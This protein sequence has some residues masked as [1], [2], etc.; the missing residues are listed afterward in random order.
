MVFLEIGMILNIED[1]AT[2]HFLATKAPRHQDA[3]YLKI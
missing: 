1:T 3:L 2:S